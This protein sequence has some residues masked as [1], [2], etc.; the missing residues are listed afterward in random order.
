MNTK[1][2][3]RV[4]EKRFVKIKKD[5]TYYV[6]DNKLDTSFPMFEISLYGEFYDASVD[7]IIEKL[8]QEDNMA[9]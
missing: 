7:Y 9:Y 4:N 6:K 5:G 1:G 3:V 2:V 8:N